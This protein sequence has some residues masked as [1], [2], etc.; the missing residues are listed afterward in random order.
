MSVSRV[1]GIAA[2]LTL[3][4]PPGVEF[5][6]PEDLLAV[7]GWPWTRL[8]R[9]AGQWRASCGCAATAERTA[10]A[11]A[12]FARSVAHLAQTLADTPAQFHE[13]CGRQ[14]WLVTLR[15]AMPLLVASP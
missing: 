15:R 3:A 1:Q 12:K 2:E 11:E 9:A 4:A 6:L 7:L 8:S 13:R 14:R 5:T 10:D